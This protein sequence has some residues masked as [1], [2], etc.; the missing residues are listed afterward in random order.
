MTEATKKR[1]SRIHD[2]SAEE[3]AE[4]AA[5]VAA[6]G[7]G[8]A[9]LSIEAGKRSVSSSVVCAPLIIP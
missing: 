8:A 2:V 1:R 7:A 6:A 4:V 9:S 3:E 5:D